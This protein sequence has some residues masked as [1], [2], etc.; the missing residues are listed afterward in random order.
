[1]PTLTIDIPEQTLA[2]LAMEPGTFAGT[3]KTMTALK[4]Y[5]LGQLASREAA[6]LAGVSHGEFL[7]LLRTHQVPPFERVD[8][9]GTPVPPVADVSDA[10]VFRLAHIQMPLWHSRRL[11]ELLDQQR[12]GTLS[13]EEAGELATLL[14]LH[15]HALLLKA[16]A[17]AEAVRRGLCAPGG[18]A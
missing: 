14:R 10:E 6:V 1:M 4:M 13:T 15:D 8:A 3:M 9:T 11:H 16:E 5:E 2:Y 7:Q 18:A 17:M 12:E